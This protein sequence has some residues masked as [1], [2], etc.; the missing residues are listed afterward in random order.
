MTG[1]TCAAASAGTQHPL[2]RDRD[3]SRVQREGLLAPVQ[4]HAEVPVTLLLRE[5]PLQTLGV[6]GPRMRAGVEGSFAI[7]S[8][9]E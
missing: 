4:E 5:E 8:R 6:P 1:R 2:E 3:D 7:H 9:R